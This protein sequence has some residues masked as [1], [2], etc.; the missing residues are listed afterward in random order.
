MKFKGFDKRN[1]FEIEVHAVQETGEDD[2]RTWEQVKDIEDTPYNRELIETLL[3]RDYEP[4]DDYA[5]VV[6]IKLKK[7]EVLELLGF[8]FYF[9]YE[10]PEDEPYWIGWKCLDWNEDYIDLSSWYIEHIYY[11]DENTY[12]YTVER[13]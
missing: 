12:R 7:A 10:K 11:Y 9:K 3:T 13:D 4:Y 8:N 1:V 5:K 2:S 6:E